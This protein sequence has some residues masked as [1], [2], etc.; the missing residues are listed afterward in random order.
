MTE[1]MT[2]DARLERIL[3]ILPR[4]ARDGGATIG[5]LATALGV[6]PAR[7][8]ADLEEAT[9]RTYHHAGGTVDPFSI[10]IEG[11]RVRVDA[12]QDFQRPVG[13]N[14]GEALALCLGLRVLAAEAAAERRAAI[15]D[16]AARLEAEL[17]PLREPGGDGVE[18][19]PRELALAFG[20]DGFRG[21]IADAIEQGVVCEI[22]YLKPGDV[23][24]EQRRIA[25][26][27]LVYASGRWYVAAWD[28]QRAGPRFFRMD[29]V[30]DALLTREAAPES[31]ANLEAWLRAAPYTASDEIDVVVKY[32]H[33]VARWILEELGGSGDDA[34]AGDGDAGAGDADAGDD[35]RTADVRVRHRVAD[36][37]WI[38]RHVLQYGGAAVIEKPD[39]ARRWVAEAAARFT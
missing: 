35:G 27:R 37:R 20:D 9:A 8:L 38:V 24:P 31:D 15:L 4:A 26:H 21:V 30:L 14:S 25:P 22:A 7:V 12:P 5:D 34:A 36:A 10:F 29:R 28:V 18:Y 17:T 3:Y 23:A 19:D 16:L 2:A 11:D 32:D 13:L 6:K 33:R 1:G 39:A